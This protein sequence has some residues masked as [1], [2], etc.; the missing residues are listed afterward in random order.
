MHHARPFW[1]PLPVPLFQTAYKIS[2]SSF[3]VLNKSNFMAS[4]PL[5]ILS[6]LDKGFLIDK[7]I[8]AVGQYALGR[9]LVSY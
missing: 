3:R 8:C 6:M 9:K 7:D 4:I 5:L 1:W 2:K